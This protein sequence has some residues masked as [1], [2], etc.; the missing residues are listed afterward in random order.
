MFRHRNHNT[1]QGSQDLLRE[2]TSLADSSENSSRRDRGIPR[3]RALAAL[4]GGVT[5]S[6]VQRYVLHDQPHETSRVNDTEKE[7]SSIDPLAQELQDSLER[8]NGE[9]ITVPIAI[10][11]VYGSNVD[12]AS[13]GG[14]G[15]DDGKRRWGADDLREKQVEPNLEQIYVT[16]GSHWRYDVRY[17][18]IVADPDAT[19]TNDDGKEER[20]YSEE[21]LFTIA[22]ERLG[23]GVVPY[24]FVDSGFTETRY[25][26]LAYLNEPDKAHIVFNTHS[27]PVGHG[28]AH[29]GWHLANPSPEH[30]GHGLAHEG[31]YDYNDIDGIGET[32]KYPLTVQDFV[33]L[34]PKPNEHGSR[35]TV[36]AA[37][38]FDIYAMKNHPSLSPRELA[39]MNRPWLTIA[40]LDPVYDREACFGKRYLTYKEGEGNTF[41]I[42]IPLPQDHVLRE[43]TPDAERLF[44]GPAFDHQEGGAA[45]DDPIWADSMKKRMEVFVCSNDGSRGHN[46]KPTP[47]FPI[48]STEGHQ[49]DVVI[50]IDEQLGILVSSGHDTGGDY[51]RIIDARAEASQRMINEFRT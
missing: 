21:Y 5:G 16:T 47:H 37:D 24:I 42:E 39:F 36:M 13:A 22:R 45:Y 25:I 44:I 50:Y 34:Q 43:L 4:I 9:T 8:S 33:K 18:D 3:R 23:E 40:E 7:K 35:L 17:V 1:V 32:S 29:E 41:G 51:V 6:L 12:P 26:G 14:N 10:V 31:L 19:R 27:G 48:R 2:D 49:G 15:V 30:F 11:A 20:Y 38:Q 46:I 28:L